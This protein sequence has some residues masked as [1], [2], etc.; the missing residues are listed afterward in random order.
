MTEQEILNTVAAAIHNQAAPGYEHGS[1]VYRTV[2]G[3]RCAIG[4]LLPDDLLGQEDSVLEIRL[5]D[6][7]VP[8]RAF[9]SALQ[10]A[11]DVAAVRNP[12][13]EAGFLAD[14]DHRI[15]ELAEHYGL[16]QPK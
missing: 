3:K 9:L 2:E 15:R 16:E 5:P 1:C 12:D 7:L 10:S 8:H 11:H 14:F 6:E 13:D 4:W